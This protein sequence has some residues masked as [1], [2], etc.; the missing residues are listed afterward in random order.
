MSLLPHLGDEEGPRLSALDTD[1]DHEMGEIEFIPPICHLP[2]EILSLIFFWTLPLVDPEFFS[3]PVIC[4]IAGLRESILQIGRVLPSHCPWILAQIC[5]R[6][7]KIALSN[8]TLWSWPV[9]AGPSFTS[10]PV[11][12]QLERSG[13]TKLH[14]CVGHVGGYTQMPPTLAAICRSSERWVEAILCINW[15]RYNEDLVALKGRV[16]NL[17]TLHVRSVWVST[18]HTTFEGDSRL[19]LFAVAPKLRSLIVVGIC[20]V[21]HSFLLPWNQLTRYQNTADA[22]DHVRVLELCPNLVEADLTLLALIRFT[23]DEKIRRLPVP[24]LRRLYVSDSAFLAYIALPAL[25]DVVLE[26]RDPE[27]D[28]L[29]PLLH[30]T[31]C[32]APPLSSVSLR[33]GVLDSDTLTSV[34]ETS[35]R[36]SVGVP[37]DSFM[38]TM[39]MPHDLLCRAVG[40]FII[41]MHCL[42]SAVYIPGCQ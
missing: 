21:A 4:G 22:V 24:H 33:S 13:K 25:E 20:D 9:I 40:L 18:A 7:R 39:P 1:T 14:V 19:A 8:H 27:A 29:F 15:P 2:A 37:Y 42:C 3:Y 38:L 17:E 6:W 34:T 31:E 5:R 32:D 26:R 10:S 30:L 35:T 28:T 36:K 41:L 23:A 12:R 11:N 16:G